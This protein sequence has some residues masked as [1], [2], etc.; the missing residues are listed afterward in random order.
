MERG[1]CKINGCSC[2]GRTPFLETTACL[3][4][5]FEETYVFSWNL[6]SCRRLLL[7]S[8]DWWRVNEKT[9]Y[10]NESCGNSLTS[11]CYCMWQV[12]TSVLLNWPWNT[13]TWDLWDLFLSWFSGLGHLCGCHVFPLDLSADSGGCHYSGGAW[14]AFW[15]AIPW[16]PMTKKAWIMVDHGDQAPV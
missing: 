8:S 9:W 16:V 10:R 7:G 6:P 5:L 4:M 1:R 11:F 15:T 13:A 12:L 2:K 14:L 3:G